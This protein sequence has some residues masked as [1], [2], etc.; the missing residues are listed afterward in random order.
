MNITSLNDHLPK[1]RFTFGRELEQITLPAIVARTDGITPQ[2]DIEVLIIDMTNRPFKDVRLLYDLY[3]YNDYTTDGNDEITEPMSDP[4]DTGLFCRGLRLEHDPTFDFSPTNSKCDQADEV[5]KYAFAKV[6]DTALYRRSRPLDGESQYIGVKPTSPL[7]DATVTGSVSQIFD[8]QAG[9]ENVVRG[10]DNEPVDRR[11]DRCLP[12]S[13]QAEEV[14]LFLNPTAP[15]N[16]LLHNLP[17]FLS[18]DN[19]TEYRYRG[20]IGEFQRVIGKLKG[21]RL[22]GLKRST[23]KLIV[24]G[25]LSL[26]RGT[27]FGENNGYDS[28]LFPRRGKVEIRSGVEHISTS[29]VED[30]PWGSMDKQ[31]LSIS[32]DSGYMYGCNIRAQNYD[33]FTNEGIQSC[34]VTAKIE[35]LIE[36][37]AD[38]AFGSNKDVVVA[39]TIET[40]LQLVRASVRDFKG[41]S[42]LYSEMRTCE[43]SQ[44][45]ASD[46]CCFNNRCWHTSL[47]S[48]CKESVEPLG[49]RKAGVSCSSDLE[50]E[51]FLL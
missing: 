51:S 16:A 2:S 34:N 3:D 37:P 33:S 32:G 27:S 31:L 26:F 44:E 35:I 4:S 22:L 41:D 45:C 10:L 39:E 40:K 21:K 48:Q 23:Q 5:C 47:V 43:N 30:A 13:I 42:V 25:S 49:F 8:S 15:I 18:G 11:R 9:V 28:L 36:T 38:S 20:L 50:C 12:D 19:E 6:V 1:V 29:K 17:I 7:I 24:T 46:E 14:S